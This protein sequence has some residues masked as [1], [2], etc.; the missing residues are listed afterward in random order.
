M[1]FLAGSFFGVG[2][3][4][5]ANGFRKVRIMSSE[6]AE[7][8]PVCKRVMVLLTVRCACAPVPEPA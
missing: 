4:M 3:V 5:L 6:W 2:G 7:K 1:G 8:G